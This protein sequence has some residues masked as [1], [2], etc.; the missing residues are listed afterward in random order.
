[1][2]A[3][4]TDY[5]LKNEKKVEQTDEKDEVETMGGQDPCSDIYIDEYVHCCCFPCDDHCDCGHC[6]C[7]HCDCILL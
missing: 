2:Y 4:K 3:S 7:G 5:L 6:D 1:M